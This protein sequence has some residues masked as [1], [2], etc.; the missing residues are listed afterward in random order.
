MKDVRKFID[1]NAI[2]R[3]IGDATYFHHSTVEA[4]IGKYTQENQI[5]LI[6]FVIN[7]LVEANIVDI[8]EIDYSAEELLKEFNDGN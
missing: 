8:M 7:D 4:L 2:G 1:E 3:K 5:A 6:K